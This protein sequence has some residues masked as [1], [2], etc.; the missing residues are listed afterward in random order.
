MLTDPQFEPAPVLSDAHVRLSIEMATDVADLAGKLS[1]VLGGGGWTLLPIGGGNSAQS[2]VHMSKLASFWWINMPAPVDPDYVRTP[3][4][5]SWFSWQRLYFDN[6]MFAAYDANWEIPGTVDT[7]YVAGAGVGGL[8]VVWYPAGDTHLETAQNFVLAA[9]DVSTR[10]K[11]EMV[12]DTGTLGIF[13]TYDFRIWPIDGNVTFELDGVSMRTPVGDFVA[14]TFYGPEFMTG[15]FRIYQSQPIVVEADEETGE[16]GYTEGD[17]LMAKIRTVYWHPVYGNIGPDITLGM[18][19]VELT[20]W[21]ENGTDHYENIIHYGPFEAHANKHQFVLWGGTGYDA[22]SQIIASLLKSH[23]NHRLGASPILVVG[24]ESTMNRI[25]LPVYTPWRDRMYWYDG[26]AEGFGSSTHMLLPATKY[27]GYVPG[28]HPI[29]MVRGLQGT[30]LSTRFG[31]PIACA[32]W[33]VLSTSPY[34]GDSG[35]IGGKL[36]D[37]LLLSGQP[38]RDDFDYDATGGALMFEGVRYESLAKNG[39]V[40]TLLHRD[41]ACTLWI[42]Q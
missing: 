30:T 36:W 18:T 8:R 25:A 15:G 42:R 40:D 22:Q 35:A 23:K 20:V 21:G 31:K 1:G 34:S 13:G 4:G 38:D 39:G 12:N 16:E 19:R 10:L 3:A 41:I 37:M 11:I 33:V 5:F 29:I 24:S 9:A 32:P 2:E 28:A 26:F 27:S 7:V 17:T 14:P 6:I